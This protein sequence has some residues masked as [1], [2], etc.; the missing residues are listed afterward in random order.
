[1]SHSYQDESNISTTDE[2]NVGE[3]DESTQVSSF[4]DES[5]EGQDQNEEDVWKGIR[6]EAFER[7]EKEWEKMVQ[8]YQQS[9]VSESVAIAKAMND[10]L[11]TLRKEF[12]EV[13]FEHL[14]W[15]HYLKKDSTYRKL[16]ETRKNLMDVDDFDWEEATESAINKRKYLLNKL[17]PKQTV[18]EEPEVNY[19]TYNPYSHKF[20]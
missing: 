11:P 2:S 7:H 3:E 8:N 17:Y 12:R 4:S 10:L 5:E 15:M 13:L 14:R 18:P 6:M 9:G 20:Y 1:M 19:Q 16:M